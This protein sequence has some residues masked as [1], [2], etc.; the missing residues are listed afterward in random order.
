M[1]L[2]NLLLAH[3]GIHNNIDIPENSL[4]AFKLAKKENVPIELDINLTKDNKLVVFHDKNTLR[5]TNKDY[6]IENILYE[7]LKKLRLLNTSERIPTLEEVLKLINGQVLIDIEVKTTTKKK[8]IVTSLL[9]E[10]K[11]YSGEVLV[12]SFD[13]AIV[14]LLKKTDYPTG[15]L[16]SSKANKVIKNINLVLLLLHPDFLSIDKKLITNKHINKFHQKKPILVWTI[17]NHD[18]L[19]KYQNSYPNYSYICNNWCS[20]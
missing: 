20:R 4:K 17:N 8:I 9:T 10:L 18:E 19:V 11:N 7:D 14:K 2:N 16:L 1:E 12:K 5:M 3:R 15:L 13:P 6:N